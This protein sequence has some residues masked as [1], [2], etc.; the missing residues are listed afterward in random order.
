MKRLFLLVL[1]T[2]L[3]MSCVAMDKSKKNKTPEWLINPKNVYPEQ[4]YLTA[5]G[6]GDTRSMAENYAAA[7]LAKI[8]ES[9]VS[10]EDTYNQRY[11]ELTS[12]EETSYE[13][14]TDVNKSVTI[15][16]DQ[17]LHNIQFADSYTDEMGRV[18]VLAYLHRMR[19]ADI[20]E[21]KISSN[22]EDILYYI[23]QADNSTNICNQYAAMSAASLISS[24]NETLLDQLDIISPDT[25]DFIEL[26]YNH[27]NVQQRAADYARGISFNI[28]IVNDIENKITDLVKNMLNEF[29]F[30][31]NQEALLDI[32]GEIKF[33]E[34][35]LNRDDFE[36][37]RYY[38]TLQMV[39]EKGDI[40]ASLN[41]KGKEGHT[42]FYEAQE[43][44]VRKI[45]DRIERSFKQKLMTYF[46]N[47]VRK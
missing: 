12:N 23:G 29:G 26:E 5:I 34:T 17:I 27:R 45:G 37:I 28:Q 43:R 31:M 19:T 22:S 1:L 25:R 2:F 21:E 36:F 6:E 46:D 38:L 44:A 33:E 7:S 32:S 8:F 10:A 16:S 13:D 3:L 42:T 4:L 9:K 40:V 47:L 24:H 14:L 39:D 20:Y 15:E 11:I 41:E 30:V 35:D 18:H